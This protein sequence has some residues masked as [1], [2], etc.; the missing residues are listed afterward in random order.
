D[1]KEKE[2]HRKYSHPGLAEPRNF[3][4]HAARLNLPDSAFR[5]LVTHDDVGISNAALKD[6][7]DRL[8]QL[9]ET[10]KIF[11]WESELDSW[12]FTYVSKHAVKIL[13]YPIDQWYEPD[14]LASHIYRGD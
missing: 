7:E 9:L 11:V 12:Q 1:G 4:T 13:G 3:V 2:F 14:F 10:T 6:S 5:V 8:R